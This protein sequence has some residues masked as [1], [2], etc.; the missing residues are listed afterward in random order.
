ME[1]NKIPDIYVI[2]AVNIGDGPSGA[3]ATI[4]LRK[5]AEM[6]MKKFPKEANII[7]RSSYVDDIVDSVATTEEAEIITNNVSFIL[8]TG[9]SHIKGWIMSGNPDEF[10][11]KILLDN[12]CERVLGLR[13][14]PE[15]DT[16][17]FNV[18]VNFSRKIKGNYSQPNLLPDKLLDKIP[19]LTKR[20]ILSQINGIY[21]PLGLVPP[22]V[23]KAKIYLRKLW[24][25]E[26]KLDWDDPIPQS[27]FKQWIDIV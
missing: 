13:W 1:T 17:I 25:L 23:V 20:M 5:I 26:P 22:F 21:D 27:L 16:L 8:K 15:T 9:N 11:W 4:A 19:S 24:A 2:T 12:N 6:G 10:E 18:R 3:I 7:T 14:I